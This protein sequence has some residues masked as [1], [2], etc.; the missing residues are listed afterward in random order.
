MLTK[1]KIHWRA[2]VWLRNCAT[3][4]AARRTLR[5]KPIVQSCVCQPLLPSRCY[6]NDLL[7]AAYL[8]DEEAEV[9][10]D[11]DRPHEDVTKD[12]G[13]EV[14]RVVQHQRAVPVQAHERPREGASSHG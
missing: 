11:R 2:M 13:D 14:V 1:A 3:P 5:Q 12:P 7:V 8:E 6:G 9:T 4:S 10:K